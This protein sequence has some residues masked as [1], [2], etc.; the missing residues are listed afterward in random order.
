MHILISQENGWSSEYL[1]YYKKINLES[2]YERWE[3]LCLQCAHWQQ[4]FPE[5]SASLLPMLPGVFMPCLAVCR[6]PIRPKK[7]N[8]EPSIEVLIYLFVNM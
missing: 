8:K 7:S 4:K 2:L 1:L 3:R 6:E 5:Y